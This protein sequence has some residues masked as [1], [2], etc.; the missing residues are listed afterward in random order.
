MEREKETRKEIWPTR[1]IPTYCGCSVTCNAALWDSE[2]Q[3]GS[4][5][6]GRDGRKDSRKR[7]QDRGSATGRIERKRKEKTKKCVQKVRLPS[8]I[9]TSIH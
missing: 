8:S 4:S 5:L 2:K 6:G 7:D 9:F 1:Y 3:T